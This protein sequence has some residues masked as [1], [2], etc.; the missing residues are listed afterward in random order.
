ML[1]SEKSRSLGAL[2]RM[3]SLFRQD[4][5]W[6]SL[7]AFIWTLRPP[8]PSTHLRICFNALLFPH[9]TSQCNLL[10]PLSSIFIFPWNPIYSFILFP[11]ES[12][13]YL[14]LYTLIIPS[15]FPY[16]LSSFAFPFTFR[17][18]PSFLSSI[19]LPHGFLFPHP[20]CHLKPFVYC[21]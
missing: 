12:F 13:F 8:H 3:F 15:P 1:G 21:Y 20:S 14:Y 2:W 17:L 18:N 7:W 10:P 19:S 16:N 11:L 5:V 4:F 9:S 6:P